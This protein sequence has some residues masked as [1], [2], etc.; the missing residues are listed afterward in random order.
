MY[1]PYELYCPLVFIAECILNV[2]LNSN[3]L[4]VL[5][6]R[7][8]WTIGS[9]SLIEVLRWASILIVLKFSDGD[10]WITATAALGA[11]TGDGLIAFWRKR[12]RTYKAVEAAL[13]A[14][15][16][17]KMRKPPFTTV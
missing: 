8:L 1:P 17:R 16:T 10:W 13:R 9:S 15:T 3:T 7:V 11:I 5:R 6:A 12:I 2:V 14:A 4:A